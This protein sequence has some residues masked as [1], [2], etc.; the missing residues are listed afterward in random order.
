LRLPFVKGAEADIT[1]THEPLP[2]R[3]LHLIYKKRDGWSASFK[4]TPITPSI[5]LSHLT[6]F[7]FAIP[8]FEVFK[9]TIP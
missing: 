1:L 8:S 3:E 5:P 7:S 2:G 4:H 6:C 9:I